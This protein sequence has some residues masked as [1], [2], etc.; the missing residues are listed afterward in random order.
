MI[1]TDDFGVQHSKE[2]EKKTSV[3]VE[4]HWGKSEISF[5]RCWCLST[6]T[7]RGGQPDGLLPSFLISS[8]WPQAMLL[9]RKERLPHLE[10][11]G[12]QRLKHAP[13]V[14]H[15]PAGISLLLSF[16]QR[17]ILILWFSLH[18][19]SWNDKINGFEKSAPTLSLWKFHLKTHYFLSHFRMTQSVGQKA[20][21]GSWILLLNSIVRY[22]WQTLTDSLTFIWQ[23]FL[24][25]LLAFPFLLTNCSGWRQNPHQKWMLLGEFFKG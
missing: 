18:S 12:D 13:W 22:I 11:L 9:T 7:R 8:G 14:P 15:P 5:W 16:I 24:A 6:A 1:W 3:K 2:T 23:K 19:S 21:F 17:T 20:P 10:V 4:K 25:V